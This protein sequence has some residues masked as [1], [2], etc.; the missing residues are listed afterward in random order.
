[1]TSEIYI[2]WPYD[3]ALVWMQAA[4]AKIKHDDL[5]LIVGC[6]S[7]RER[8][9]TVGK[10]KWNLSEEELKDISAPGRIIRKIE[11][12]GGLTAHEPG[13]LVLYPIFS[14]S[15]F[16]LTV[17]AL[18]DLLEE[19]M[20]QFL[21]SLGIQA[22]RSSINPGVF[23]DNKKIGF[24]GLRIKEGIVSHGL[25]LNMIND[26]AIFTDFDP[27]GLSSLE[28]TSAQEHVSLDEP[29]SVYAERLVD[30]FWSCLAAREVNVSHPI[31]E[32]ATGEGL[33]QEI[34]ATCCEPN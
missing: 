15:R 2:N 26:H 19:T 11:R 10:Q 14:L 8:V 28:I 5:S 20:L 6:G 17:P 18:V 27:C 30:Q 31:H 7:H 33:G 13:Q 3:D 32:S 29:L 21:S 1:M 12:G 34:R 22:K 25:S 4:H 23:I 16:A 24:I 9:I